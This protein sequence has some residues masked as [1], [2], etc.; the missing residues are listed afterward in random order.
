MGR[1]AFSRERGR[2]R[3]HSDL[4][5]ALGPLTSILSPLQGRGETSP[6]LT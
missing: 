5:C 2:V 1:L 3:V 4:A 6:R